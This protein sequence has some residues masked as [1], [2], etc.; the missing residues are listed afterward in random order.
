M[1]PHLCLRGSGRLSARQDT[2]FGCGE[3]PEQGA[4]AWP[5]WCRGDTGASKQQGAGG[6]CRPGSS[7]S[8]MYGGLLSTPHSCPSQACSGTYHSPAI[9]CR[10]GRQPDARDYARM[11]PSPELRAWRA[12]RTSTAVCRPSRRT[13]SSAQARAQALH[14]TASTRAP[15]GNSRASPTASAPLPAPRS[16]HAPPRSSGR[17]AS[18]CAGAAGLLPERAGRARRARAPSG[19]SWLS[20]SRGFSLQLILLVTWCPSAAAPASAASRPW[21]PCSSPAWTD[22]MHAGLTCAPPLQS[23][24]GAPSPGAG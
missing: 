21:R 22:C 16:A 20:Q 2:A 11:P 7:A 24:P 10:T 6:A 5:H 4:A 13:F 8:S 14:S 23:R 18:A 9:T 3:Q 17:A 1:Q 12:R 19:R 15:C